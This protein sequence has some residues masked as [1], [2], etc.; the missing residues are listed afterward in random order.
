MRASNE[1]SL[2]AYSNCAIVSLIKLIS[3]I[4]AIIANDDVLHIVDWP[5]RAGG[6]WSR[7]CAVCLVERG[8]WVLSMT[9]EWWLNKWIFYIGKYDPEIVRM[10]AHE[11]LAEQHSCSMCV[12]NLRRKWNDRREWNADATSIAKAIKVK[13]VGA[14][15]G[16]KNKIK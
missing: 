11:S 1:L 5:H 16:W 14:K 7:E 12:A 15:S 4:E 9:D 13:C 6:V 2:A 3:C 10:I 8:K